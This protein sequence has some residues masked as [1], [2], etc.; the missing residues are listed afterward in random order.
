MDKINIILI[1]I[2]NKIAKQIDIN[3]YEIFLF[4]SRANNSSFKTSDIDIGILGNKALSKS[5]LNKIKDDIKKINTLYFIDIV[6]FFDA[7]ND[8][9]EIALKQRKLLNEKGLKN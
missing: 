7:S 3:N 8:F 6:D 1:E 9:K 2:Y 4:G 5:T